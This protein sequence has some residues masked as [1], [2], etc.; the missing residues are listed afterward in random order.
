MAPKGRMRDGV[1]ILRERYIGDD[2]ERLAQVHDEQVSADVAQLIYDA[3]TNAGL[4]QREL[5]AL[6]GTTQSV[7]SRLEDS[8]YEGRSLTMLER[9]A[10]ALNKKLTVTMT[11]RDIGTL[12]RYMPSENERYSKLAPLGIILR[13]TIAW[14][15]VEFFKPQSYHKNCETLGRKPNPGAIEPLSASDFLLYLEK[16]NILTEAR[17]YVFLIRH[18]LDKMTSANILIDMGHGSRVNVLIPRRYYFIKELTAMQQLG[19]FWLAPAL[20]ADFIFHYARPGIVHITGTNKQG[21][22]VAGSGIVFHQRH[23][24]TCAHVLSDMNVDSRQLFQGKECVVEEQFVHQ[25]TDVAVL[26]VSRSLS[27]VPGLSFLEPVIAQSVLVL[28]YPKIPFS[29]EAALTI[30]PG[31]VTS[32]SVSA[33]RGDKL[34]LYSAIARPG[35]SGGPVISN[36]GYILGISSEDLS[37]KEDMFSPHYAG[38]PSQEIV[39]AVDELGIGVQIPFER[40]D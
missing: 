15:A 31:S 32:E 1:T 40:F 13:T 35:N 2:P 36:E 20:G 12:E 3:R 25:K 26:R 18:L 34:F 4:S 23:V 7:I 9:I 5:A 14:A 28:G 37:C 8:D 22:P 6:I 21:D 16:K 39:A 38:V 27:P 17:R 24:L 10:R 30:Q 29:R 33:L 11:E 19:M